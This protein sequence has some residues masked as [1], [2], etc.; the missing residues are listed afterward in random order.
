M[1]EREKILARIR[2]ALSVPAHGRGG[3]L[4]TVADQ[5]RVMPAVGTTFDEQ[6]A[7]FQKNAADLRADFRIVSNMDELKS[8]LQALGVAESWKRI[9]S[10]GGKLAETVVPALELSSVVH[11]SQSRQRRACTL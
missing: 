2:E 1:S 8:Q 3:D 5:R 7:L 6:L 4:P 9:A 11:R 10:H